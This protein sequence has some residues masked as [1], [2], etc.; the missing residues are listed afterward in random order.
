MRSRLR[1][2]RAPALIECKCGEPEESSE[3]GNGHCHRQSSRCFADYRRERKAHHFGIYVQRRLQVCS[4]CAL[5]KLLC[6]VFPPRRVS[7]LAFPY[8]NAI[9]TC[10]VDAVRNRY[11]PHEVCAAA[12]LGRRDSFIRTNRRLHIASKHASRA[13]RSEIKVKLLE[14]PGARAGTEDANNRSSRLISIQTQCSFS[15]ALSS[16]S[17]GDLF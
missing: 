14:M 9:V 10:A 6:A 15:V 7:L 1:S 12:A 5:H 17:H 2:E 11:F 13:P 3:Q 16:L 4:L 8:V